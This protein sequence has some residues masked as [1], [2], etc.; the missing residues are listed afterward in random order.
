MRVKIKN[1]HIG[2][3]VKSEGAYFKVSKSARPVGMIN[4]SAGKMINSLA[5]QNNRV[6]IEVDEEEKRIY[7]IPTVEGEFRLT[8]RKKYDGYNIS[9]VEIK[10]NYR[11]VD[12]NR[13]PVDLVNGE[14]VIDFSKEVE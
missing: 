10:E 9:M 7:I 5:L 14:I 13:H 12:Y 8:K 3:G 1:N 4:V 11:F 2:R 6:D